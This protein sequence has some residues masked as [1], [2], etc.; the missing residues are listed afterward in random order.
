M[1]ASSPVAPAAALRTSA[2]VLRTS[3]ANKKAHH[4]Y[5]SCSSRRV[6]PAHERRSRPAFVRAQRADEVGAAAAPT[7]AATAVVGGYRYKL[8]LA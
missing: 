8:T 6:V 3:A 7:V 1:S 5:H 4:R 2:V